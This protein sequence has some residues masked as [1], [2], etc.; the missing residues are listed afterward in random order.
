[1]LVGAFRTMQTII[2]AKRTQ[3]IV[4]GERVTVL[5]VEEVLR[6]LFH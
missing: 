6:Y 3:Y 4:Y 5:S 2:K 1:M